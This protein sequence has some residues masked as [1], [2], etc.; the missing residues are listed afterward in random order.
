M[1]LD[2]ATLQRLSTERIEDSQCLLAGQRWSGAYY[3]AG[4]ALES[5]LKSCVVAYVERNI[6]VLFGRHGF[7]QK[8]WTH[9]LETLLEQADLKNQKESWNP[10]L[11]ENWL[12]AKDWNEASRYESKNESSTR[13]L[14]EA[15][16]DNNEGVLKWLKN[17]W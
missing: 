7:Q 3:L 8:C 16:T 2:R 9:N 17:F 11:L 10:E 6:S 15:I 13:K 4:Y 5:A 12:I 1:V 14:Y